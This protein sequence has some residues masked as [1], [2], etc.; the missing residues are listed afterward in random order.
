MFEG[1]R[2]GESPDPR[3]TR[4]GNP[5]NP[6]MVEPGERSGARGGARNECQATKT[7][8]LT[9]RWPLQP[10]NQLRSISQL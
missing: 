10:A 2:G 8:I 7:C 9:P 6:S 3:R 5:P 4:G 1:E